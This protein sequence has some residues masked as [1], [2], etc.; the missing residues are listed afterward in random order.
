M[1][2][3]GKL[4]IF[5][6]IAVVFWVVVI[7]LISLSSAQEEKAAAALAA[8]DADLVVEQYV[9]ENNELTGLVYARSDMH[10]EHGKLV[11][12]RFTQRY[13]TEENAIIAYRGKAASLG[14]SAQLMLDGLEVSYYISNEDF[15]E[16]TYQ[17]M[18][19]MMSG[20]TSGWDVVEELSG[21][22]PTGTSLE[23]AKNGGADAD[24]GD[25]ADGE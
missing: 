23:Y 3:I 20:A 24:A 25:N 4:A 22:Y 11:T 2:V 13:A 10:W 7:Q 21:E 15:A 8:V 5:A 17:D 14:T 18:Y 1:K 16:R 19:E 9:T 12:M 6:V